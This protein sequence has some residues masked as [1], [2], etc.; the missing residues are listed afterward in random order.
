MTLLV[1]LTPVAVIAAGGTFTDDDTSIFEAD[2]EWLADHGITAG[3]N[4]PANDHF[5]PK[6][7][8][9]R[10]QMAAF[11]HRFA[12][13][14]STNG[15]SVWHDNALTVTGGSGYA[16]LLTL[17]SIPAGSYIFIAKT[18]FQGGASQGAVT[19]RLAAG[20]DYDQLSATLEPYHHVP[21]TMTVVH[22]FASSGN[23]VELGCNASTSPR[24]NNTKITAIE[25]NSLTN[26]PG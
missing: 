4:P 10:G 24:L 19:C 18:H 26:N 5:C 16:P 22:T 8:V 12:N 6:A 25:V 17:E 9:T 11:L 1:L 3:C 20:A 7:N 13:D 2:I 15:L 14:Q 23:T 21:A